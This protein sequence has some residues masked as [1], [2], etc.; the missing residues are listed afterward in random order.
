MDIANGEPIVV[1]IKGKPKG[2]GLVVRSACDVQTKI[3][4]GLDLR[5]GSNQVRPAK[6]DDRFPATTAEVLR[7]AEPWQGKRRAVFADSRYGS[8]ATVVAMKQQ[9]N[10]DFGGVVKTNTALYPK[11]HFKELDLTGE[12]RGSGHTLTATI[13][14]VNAYLLGV[15]HT[16]R[17]IKYGT[18]PNFCSF[19]APLRPISTLFGS[20]DMSGRRKDTTNPLHVRKPPVIRRRNRRRCPCGH[21][22]RIDNGNTCTSKN[23]ILRRAAL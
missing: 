18:S 8:V 4:L 22:T 2:I 23:G 11:K 16:R 10:T 19:S 9:F 15:T 21:L 14:G 12:E 1:K 6:F 13:G 3:M 17:G 7:L 20:M 5:R